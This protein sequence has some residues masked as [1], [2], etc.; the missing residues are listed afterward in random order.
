MKVTVAS[1]VPVVVHR[2]PTWV[3][4]LPVRL[5]E[6]D[7]GDLPAASRGNFTPSST[8]PLSATSAVAGATAEGQ[9]V[10]AAH[11]PASG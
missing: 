8:A 5:V 2:L 9:I 4:V 1:R 7:A 11:P 6:A 3:P 10:Q